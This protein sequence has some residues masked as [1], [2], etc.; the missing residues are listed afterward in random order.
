MQISKIQFIKASFWVCVHDLS[1]MA[2]NEYIGRLVGNSIGVEKEIDLDK[3]EIEWRVYV[4]I[5]EDEHHQT[6]PEKEET[7]LGLIRIGVGHSLI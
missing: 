2:C 6:H 4:H 3:G 5:G 1:L 7:E